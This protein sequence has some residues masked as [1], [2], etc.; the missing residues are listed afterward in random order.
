MDA[1][2]TLRIDEATFGYRGELVSVIIQVCR[3]YKRTERKRE[4]IVKGRSIVV[5]LLNGRRLEGMRRIVQ[6]MDNGTT[7]IKDG[8]GF[9]QAKR[10]I[11][12]VDKNYHRP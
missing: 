8:F 5:Q 7:I 11:S 12:N 3:R 9:V 2:A 1:A 4:Y 6:W 10:S